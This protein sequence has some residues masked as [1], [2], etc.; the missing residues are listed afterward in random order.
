MDLNKQ[1]LQQLGEDASN[2]NSIR[3]K[4]KI[5]KELPELEAQKKGRNV[6]LAFQD[7]VGLALSESC[8]YCD[9]IILS[10][11]AKVLRCHML[12]HKI[13]ADGILVYNM[14]STEYY[15]PSSLL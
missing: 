2:I 5:L 15:A 10:K 7:D 13:L 3:L 6:L 14:D 12:D 9:A 11:A 4:E 1:R 8:A